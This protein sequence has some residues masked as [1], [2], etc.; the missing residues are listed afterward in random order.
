MR[1]LYPEA[2]EFN[3]KKLASIP[4][5]GIRFNWQVGEA[6]RLC[7]P[8]GEPFLSTIDLFH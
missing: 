2:K 8:D 1:V 5:M 7:L 4:K 6:L 3:G